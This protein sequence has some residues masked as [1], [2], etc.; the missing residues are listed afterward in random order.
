MI[1][2][3]VFIYSLYCPCCSS[4]CVSYSTYR[5]LLELIKTYFY[6]S[7]SYKTRMREVMTFVDKTDRIQANPWVFELTQIMLVCSNIN[8]S[9]SNYAGLFQYKQ[10]KHSIIVHFTPQIFLTKHHVIASQHNQ[11]L[12]VKT[13]VFSFFSAANRHLRNHKRPTEGLLFNLFS[14]RH[15]YRKPCLWENHQC[16]SSK[17]VFLAQKLTHLAASVFVHA[18]GIIEENFEAFFASFVAFLRHNSQ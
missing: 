1:I 2:S 15:P 18:F 5:L 16:C 13:R 9:S 7:P 6:L 12:C 11:S 10:N 14:L 3:I 8:L 17:D 4:L